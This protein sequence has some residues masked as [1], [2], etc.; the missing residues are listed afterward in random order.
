MMKLIGLEMKQ[1]VRSKWLQIVTLLFVVT[2]TSVLLIQQLA[3]PEAQGFSRQSAALL[4]VLLFLLPLFML[5]IGAMS[6]A[7]DIESG[8]LNLLRTYPLSNGTY[9]I[10]K[11][12]GLF[13]VFSLMTFLAIVVA[14]TIGALFGGISLDVSLL[15]LIVSMVFIFTALATLTGSLAKNRLHALALGLGV[16]SFISL[17]VSYVLMAVGTL[18]PEHILKVLIVLNM[19]VNPLEWMRFS[20]FLFTGQTAILGPE[21]YELVK[22][23][24]STMGIVYYTL[25]T[26]L[27]IITPLLLATF[28]LTK[29]GTTV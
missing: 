26:V 10:T 24:D 5:S 20:Y 1:L 29:R 12:L 25:I 3:I 23:Y 11:W 19:H 2:F 17:I 13:I 15:I 7:A 27:W 4:N 9:V 22:F 14:M 16:W 21:F 28:T 18:L 6:I 8:W